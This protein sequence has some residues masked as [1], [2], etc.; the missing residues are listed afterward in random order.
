MDLKYLTT[1]AK[2][3]VP[4]EAFN[5]RKPS[6]AKR[7]VSEKIPK[8]TETTHQIKQQNITNCNNSLMGLVF[9]PLSRTGG[10]V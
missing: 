8:S 3:P 4:R 7:T 6:H 1:M 2:K 5:H 10:L 9:V